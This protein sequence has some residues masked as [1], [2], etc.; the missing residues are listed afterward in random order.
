M[1]IKGTL[2]TAY[3]MSRGTTEN[4]IGFYTFLRIGVE[5]SGIL[6]DWKVWLEALG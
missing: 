6:K 3:G 4:W 2:S 5:F 1:P